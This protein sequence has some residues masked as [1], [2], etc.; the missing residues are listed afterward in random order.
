MRR[1]M[2]KDN[3]RGEQS[4]NCE[5]LGAGSLT[6][7]LLEPGLLLRR[8]DGGLHVIGMEHMQKCRGIAK[9][10]REWPGVCLGKAD[11]ELQWKMS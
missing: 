7:L 1:H 6:F 11:I 3:C 10:P 8:D 2:A 5:S 9:E 4:A